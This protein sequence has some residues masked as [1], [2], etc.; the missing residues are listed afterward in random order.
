M[1]QSGSARWLAAGS[2]DASLSLWDLD[3]MA[4]VWSRSTIDGG[5]L[6]ITFSYGSAMLA[7]TEDKASA[8]T[9]LDT[10]S[11]ACACGQGAGCNAGVHPAGTSD[12]VHGGPGCEGCGGKA[13]R[14]HLQRPG[15]SVEGFCPSPASCQQWGAHLRAPGPLRAAVL[16]SMGCCVPIGCAPRAGEL[17]SVTTLNCS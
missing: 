8:V 1:S 17:R 3:E 5:I 12:L 4:A 10:A 15:A 9:H 11:G 13:A 2:V 16:G 7:Y 6:S 14:G